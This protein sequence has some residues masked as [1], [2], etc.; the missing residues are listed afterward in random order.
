MRNK[1]F[2]SLSFSDIQNVAEQELGRKLTPD[3]IDK[4]ADEVSKRIAWY[5]IIADVLLVE[6]EDGE[7]KSPQKITGI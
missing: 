4:V 7:K 1:V 5:G 3:E 6:I 2:Y